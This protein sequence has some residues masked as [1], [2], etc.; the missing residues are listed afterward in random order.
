[1]DWGIFRL[2]RTTTTAVVLLLFSFFLMT[3]RLTK[4]V[5]TFRSLLFY[6]I[7]PSQEAA[8]ALF[9]NA[10]EAGLR[11][12]ELVRAHQENIALKDAA[13]RRSLLEA[14][15]Q[16]VL[17]ENARLKQ[18]LQLK[19]SAPFELIPAIVSGRDTQNWTQAVWIDH[20]SKEGILPDSPVLVI[21]SDPSDN[22]DSAAISTGLI[23][24]VLECGTNSSRVL[25][26]SDPLSSV[27]AVLPRTGEQGLVTGQGLFS[28]TIEYLDPGA[29]IKIGDEVITS[30]LGGIFPA[31]LRIGTLAK[32]LPS[33]S[34]FK[35]V[36]LKTSASLNKIREVLVLK[37]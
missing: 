31:G 27:A 30:G 8:T 22:S 25:L 19:L 24:R 15:Y 7:S 20:G 33:L 36:E 21:Q 37:K 34:G 28:A 29:D 11:S 14:E 17:L 5:Q 13:R 3:L 12:R 32:I 23:G 1:M 4:P 26:I 35:R 18:L 6:W 10:S 2:S 9:R 16:E